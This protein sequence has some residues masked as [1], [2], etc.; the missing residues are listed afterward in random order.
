MKRVKDFLVD[1]L[2]ERSSWIAL[3]FILSAC[4]FKIAAELNWDS[5]SN[6]GL[7]LAASIQF[8]WPDEKK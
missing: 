5:A 2:K 8:I 3:G 7:F 4:G 6:L 1:R